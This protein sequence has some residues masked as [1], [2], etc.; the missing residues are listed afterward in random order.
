M[1]P[2]ITKYKQKDV[3]AVSEN[4]VDALAHGIFDKIRRGDFQIG[5][6]SAYNRDKISGE[7][8]SL[9]SKDV[10]GTALILRSVHKIGKKTPRYQIEI[11]REEK[12]ST[13]ARTILGGAWA[14]KSF[15]FFHR[16]AKKR[17]IDE[18]E[19]SSIAQNLGIKL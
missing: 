15:A 8:I 11:F 14:R 7:E 2:K 10:K 19:I 5:K 18:K 17:K 16:P 12:G 3:Q 13:P 4:A 9:C 1:S 6:S